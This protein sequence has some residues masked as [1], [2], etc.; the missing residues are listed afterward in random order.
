MADNIQASPNVPSTETTAV[1]PE[2]T[3][4][5]AEVDTIVQNRLD[6]ERKNLPSKDELTAFRNWRAS[7]QTE[8]ERVNGI[9]EERDGNAA[10]LREANAKVEQF[11]RERLLLSKGV[12]M[13]DVEYYAF[14]IGKLVTETQDFAKSV[15]VFFK[16]NAQQRA[17]IDMTGGM[18]GK[19]AEKT[20]N[21]SMNDWIR[22]I[23]NR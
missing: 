16:D 7:Q 12:P 8:E 14:K 21:Q 23:R 1:Q 11:E 5:Q 10:A 18:N 17:R 19:P 9:I 22:G 4:T 2:R 3:F 6:R 13:E 15:E 20:A